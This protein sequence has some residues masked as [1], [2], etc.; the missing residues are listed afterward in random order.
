MELIPAA[1]ERYVHD[2]TRPED[3]PMAA[4][5]PRRSACRERACSPDGSRGAS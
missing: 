5:A 4:I 1:I 3:E 2:H